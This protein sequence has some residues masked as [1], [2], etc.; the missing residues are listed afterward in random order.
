M[1]THY[2]T[3]IHTFLH[4]LRIKQPLAF[5]NIET[6]SFSNSVNSLLLSSLKGWCLCCTSLRKH[7]QNNKNYWQNYYFVSLMYCSPGCSTHG[8][9]QHHLQVSPLRMGHSQPNLQNKSIFIIIIIL[10]SVL[11][12]LAEYFSL[13][14]WTCSS[15]ATA[16]S[17]LSI[18]SFRKCSSCDGSSFPECFTWTCSN[19]C[20][21]SQLW[22]LIFPLVFH[23]DMLQL[24]QLI[25]P[26]LHGNDLL[27]LLVSLLS[28]RNDLLRLLVFPVTWKLPSV[29]ACLP[30][31]PGND[32]L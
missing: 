7:E 6:E 1:E 5:I 10:C 21:F 17:F 2:F 14:S 20:S 31:S 29:A 13:Y 8:W 30:L 26:L 3:I 12:E 32:L 9:P 25:F 11:V 15:P 24:L 19:C 28:S 18:L 16:T 4:R 27:W 23:L 22:Q